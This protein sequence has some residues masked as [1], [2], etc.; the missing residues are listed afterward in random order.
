MITDRV[1]PHSIDA[2][3]SVLGAL[4]VDDALFDVAAGVVT[5]RDFF[6]DAHQELWKAFV[7]LREQSRPLDLTLVV[8]ELKIRQTLERCDG[9]AYVSSLMDGVPRS[10]NVEHYAQVVREKSLLRDLIDAANGIAADA[11]EADEHADKI[12]DKAE[13]SIMA[14]G[15]SASKGDF[16][17]ADDWMRDTFRLVEKAATDKRVVTGVPSGIGSLDVITRGWQNGDLIYL[18]ARPSSGKTALALQLALEASKHTMTGFISLEMSRHMIGMR[19]VALEAGVDAFRLMTGHLSDHE[20]RQTSTAMESLG[21]RRFAIDDASGS[22]ATQLRSKARRFASK[23]GLGMLFVD[24][25][26]LVHDTS[27]KGENR[28]QELSKISWGWKSLARDLDIPVF[29]LSQ[30]SRNNDK[31][32]RRPKLSDLRDSGSLEQDADLVL[33]LYRPQQADGT[34]QDGEEAEVIVAKQ[35]NGPIG[36]VKMQWV[37]QQMR[38]KEQVRS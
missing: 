31:E 7:S 27:V 34:F 8:E 16:V 12:L 15:S 17:L 32:N 19:A 2:E 22:T 4:M 30:L 29:V 1:R 10:T 11:Y 25:M 9:P 35:R 6:R 14:V 26:Q 18:G 21:A 36:P 5:T 28:N 3:K 24:Y 23:H 20:L 37:G 13:K 33:L 38:F